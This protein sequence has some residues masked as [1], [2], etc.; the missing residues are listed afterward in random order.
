MTFKIL[1][2]GW[3]PGL[4]ERLLI[5]IGQQLGFEFI[6]GLVGDARRLEHVA[7]SL[8]SQKF[9]SLSKSGQAALPEADLAL[10]GGLESFGVPTF[11]AMIQ[12]D[13]VLRHRSEREALGYATL[14]ARNLERAIETYQPDLVLGSHDS[15]HA[16]IGLA[17]SKA[18]G[19]PWVTLVFSVIPDDLTGFSKALTPD[20]LVPIKRDVTD[21]LRAQA[22]GIIER[23]R[24]KD[25]QV[26]A[27][28]PPATLKQKLIQYGDAGRNLYRRASSPSRLG[29]DAFTFPT[30]TERAG[31]LARRMA[32]SAMLP[33]QQMLTAPPLGRY[34]YFP[35]HMAPESM[36]DTWAPFYQDQLAFVRQLSLS[37]PIGLELVVKLHFSSPDNYTRKQ[38]RQLMSLPR[39]KIANPNAS[40]AALMEGADLVIGIQGTSSLEAALMGKPVLMF[41]DSPYLHFPYTE[42]AKR[43][44]E[45]FAQIAL[46]LKQVNRQDSAIVEAYATYLARY[47]PGRINNWE[48]AITATEL[49]RYV[50]CFSSLRDYIGVPGTIT[51]WYKSGTFL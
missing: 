19:V 32:N 43:P 5:P 33:K 2:V 51:N 42:R 18:H 41:G 38:L 17:V 37:L 6:H 23:V 34:A 39:V 47:M 9:L 24:G 10:L 16:A 25:Q 29:V 8:P 12:G 31:D 49:E 22:Q 11:R 20:Q 7:K 48:R 44:D 36:L 45:L 27:Y 40:G 26:L 30:I 46:M 28:R 3:E 4:I 13:R 21:E 1:T 15:L 50:E 35:L 14:I